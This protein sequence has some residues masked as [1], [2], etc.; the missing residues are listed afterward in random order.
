MS[1]HTTHFS[2]IDAIIKVIESLIPSKPSYVP[3]PAKRR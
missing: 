1:N 2:L 3:I